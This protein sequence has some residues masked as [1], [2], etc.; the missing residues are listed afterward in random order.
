MPAPKAE[1]LAYELETPA[2]GVTANQVT[3]AA[4]VLSLGYGTAIVVTVGAAGVR[5][6]VV[7][8]G[9]RGALPAVVDLGRDDSRP[10]RAGRFPRLANGLPPPGRRPLRGS[11]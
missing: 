5:G 7:R 11:W 9:P 2:A 10:P 1:Q 3:V 6:G 8:L 4:V